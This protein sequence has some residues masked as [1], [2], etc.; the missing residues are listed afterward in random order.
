MATVNAIKAGQWSNADIWN[1]KA[2]P[3]IND[4]VYANGFAVEIN[5]NVTVSSIRGTA[6]TMNY[7]LAQMCIPL[8]TSNT[9]EGVAFSGDSAAD[10]FEAFDRNNSTNYTTPGTTGSIG[11]QFTSAKIIKVYRIGSLNTK[12]PKRWTF[13]GSNDGSNWTTLDDK[14]GADVA[15]FT[16]FTSTVLANTTAYTYYRLNIT[17]VTGT[18]AQINDFEMTEYNVATTVGNVGGYFYANSAFDI[19]ATNFYGGSGTTNTAILRL[20]AE[21]G[22][23]NLTGNIPYQSWGGSNPQLYAISCT[24]TCNLVF[25]GN[26]ST[27][28]EQYNYGLYCTNAGTITITGTITSQ[29]ANSI[30]LNINCVSGTLNLQGA[31]SATASVGILIAGGINVNISGTITATAGAIADSSTGITTITSSTIT[32]AGGTG[33]SKTAGGLI[34]NGTTCNGSS[35]SSIRYTAADN[36][37]TLSFIGKIDTTSGGGGIAVGGQVSATLESSDANELFTFGTGLGLSHSGTGTVTINSDVTLAGS[38]GENGN[39]LN[40]GSGTLT[41]NGNVL[42]QLAGTAYIGIRA[43]S[44]GTVI[45][46][47]NVTARGCVYSYGMT[48]NVSGGASTWRFNGNVTAGSYSSHTFYAYTANALVYCTGTVKGGSNSLAYGIYCPAYTVLDLTNIE[49]GSANGVALYC[50]TLCSIIIRGNEVYKNGICPCYGLINQVWRV[51]SID[52][53]AIVMQDANN[54]DRLFT[55]DT[56]ASNP[57]DPS[58]VRTGITYGPNLEFTGVCAVPPKESVHIGIP[59]DN[60]VGTSILTSQAIEIVTAQILG[61]Q[62]AAFLP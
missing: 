45:F 38:P 14:S 35:G 8:L 30:A 36:T 44:G 19:T 27:G 48:G 4:D 41:F 56:F 12:C 47:G 53:Q 42:G 46:N 18:A 23:F 43:S 50:S 7:S 21:S 62:L 5:Q 55:N 16:T 54:I 59:V 26:I 60:T 2:V 17:T 57:P 11:Y 33:I 10:A 13:Q 22:T 40:S 3:G 31:I 20:S 9:S 52:G 1:T 24:G 29:S 58:D 61:S 49:C 34:V 32:A 6:G 37:K 15:A 51:D 39:I 25:N 28:S